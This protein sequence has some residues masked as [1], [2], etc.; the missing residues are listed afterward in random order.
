M[1]WMGHGGGREIQEGGD[2]CIPM[3]NLGNQ[4]W[5][6]IGR[7]DAEAEAPILWPHGE[8]SWLIG[9]D[10]DSGKDQRQEEK[11]TTE[12]EMVDGIT[13]SWVWASSGKWWRTAKPGML[14]SMVSQRV[15]H[16]CTT[17]L[18]WMAD[19]TALHCTAEINTALQSTPI[20]K[21]KQWIISTK[22]YLI[23]GNLQ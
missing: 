15:R 9:K 3:P 4:P 5:M 18:N 22:K 13:N 16:D 23:I 21:I 11:G 8:K 17:E 20:W 19:C 12:N 6:F 1:G 2:I 14:Q 7:T 10:P